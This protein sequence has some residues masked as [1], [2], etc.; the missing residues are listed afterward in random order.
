MEEVKVI[1]QGKLH[2]ETGCQMYFCPMPAVA[3][4]EYDG[5]CAGKREL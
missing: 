2:E 1:G 3:A 5:N 4:A